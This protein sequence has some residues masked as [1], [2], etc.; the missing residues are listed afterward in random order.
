MLVGLHACLKPP[1][2][3]ITPALTFDSVTPDS[4]HQTTDTVVFK[5]N[6]TDGDG[7]LGVK[8]GENTADFF[9]TD[10]RTGFVYSNLIPFVEPIGNI[11]A[12]SGNFTYSTVLSCRPNHPGFDTTSYSIYI[13]DRAGHQSNTVTTPPIV[14]KCN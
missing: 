7:D 4:C 9:M 10:S 8:Q 12:I 13:V 11:K 2:Y 1:S 6:F 5:I 3:P 14:L